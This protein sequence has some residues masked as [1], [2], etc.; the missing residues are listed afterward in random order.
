MFSRPHVNLMESQ[1]G[2]SVEILSRTKLLYRQGKKSM[3][4]DAEGLADPAFLI[5]RNSMKTWLPPYDGEE[6]SDMDRDKIIENI[7][8]AFHF[9]G[10]E[11]QVI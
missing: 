2:Y 4:I 6:I 3:Y 11:L 7:R 8:A 9:Y 10:M 5:Y 1:N